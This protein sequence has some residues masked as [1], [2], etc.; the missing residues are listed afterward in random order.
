MVATDVGGNSAAVINGET[1]VL[2]P[3]E[4]PQVLAQAIVS[5][6][7]APATLTQY[8]HAARALFDA[9]F[10]ASTMTRQYERLYRRAPLPIEHN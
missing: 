4:N 10:S 3:P 7:A 1:G 2:V 9:K 6:L 5:L 8:A